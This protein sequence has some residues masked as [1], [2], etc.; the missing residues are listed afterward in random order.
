[1]SARV[2]VYFLSLE[3][4]ECISL[5][6]SHQRSTRLTKCPTSRTCC[7]VLGSKEGTV[8]SPGKMP[9]ILGEVAQM[10]ASMDHAQKELVN[11]GAGPDS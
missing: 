1:M 3:V 6:T 4:V 11:R 2:W 5:E 9:K 10:F 8:G 7:E